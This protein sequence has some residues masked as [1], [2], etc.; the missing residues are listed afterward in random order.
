MRAKGG[1]LSSLVLWTVFLS[2][3][4]VAVLGAALVLVP[5]G[6]RASHWIHLRWCRLAVRIFGIDLKVEH[7]ERIV[8]D[9]PVIFFANHQSFM[10]IVI[11]GAALQCQYR[12]LAKAELFK[13]PILGW[14]MRRTGYV[15]V[16]RGS[17][18]KALESFFRAADRV[19]AGDSIVVFPEA[20][21]TP[22]GALLP[23]KNG[24]FQIARRAGVT[25]QA[26]T[27]DGAFRVM[28]DQEDKTI[29]RIRSGPVRVHV[30]EPLEVEDYGELAIDRFKGLVRDRIQEA[31]A[32]G[33]SAGKSAVGV[34]GR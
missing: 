15:P 9:R 2:V 29:A 23:F 3:S 32:A 13:I 11:V 18:A 21:V 30:H 27:I 34:E 31:L 5:F 20:T 19:R 8:R 28:P 25:V 7:P 24:G 1:F 14:G 12:W 16:E 4:V 22:D 26:L 10:D 17:S 6:A 33:S